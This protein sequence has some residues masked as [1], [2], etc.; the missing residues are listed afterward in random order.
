MAYV[1]L[2]SRNSAKGVGEPS[3]TTTEPAA[4]PTPAPAPAVTPQSTAVATQAPGSTVTTPPA[5]V[6][7]PTPQPQ[8]SDRRTTRPPARQS[9]PVRPTP[10]PVTQPPPAAPAVEEGFLTID[11]DPFGTVFVDGVNAGPTPLVQYGVKPGP[12]QIRI[13]NPGYKTVTDR[14]QVDAGNT[15]RKRYTL[16]PE[17]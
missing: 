1:V 7:K 15:V 5:G 11:A 10:T 3:A 2:S 17:G 8:A 6:A 9:A 12:H 14:V 16:T 13:E 4:T